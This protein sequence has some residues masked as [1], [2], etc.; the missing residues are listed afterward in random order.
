M[1][2]MTAFLAVAGLGMFALTTGASAQDAEAGKK[3][4]A[5]CTACHGIGDTKKNIGPSL[6]GVVGRTAGTQAEFLAKK[7]AG[8]S[9]AMT[10]AGA[11]GLV[12]DDANISEYL[13]DP[14]KKVPKNKMAFPGLK[15]EKDRLDVIAYLKTFP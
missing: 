4:F 3:V 2:R 15:V 8:Y 10:D 5:K 7:A 11:A 14:K 6:T 9:K 12:W 13:T 1:R